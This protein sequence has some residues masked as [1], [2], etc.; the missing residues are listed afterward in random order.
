MKNVALTA[1][2]VWV[3]H[4]KVVLITTDDEADTFFLQSERSLNEERQGN[5]GG[6]C[7]L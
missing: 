7:C 4:L 1:V 5:R 2:I 3:K 6:W